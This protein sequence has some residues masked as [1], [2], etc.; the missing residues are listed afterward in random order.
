MAV[1]GGGASGVEICAE[2]KQLY[3]VSWHQLHELMKCTFVRVESTIYCLRRIKRLS[4]FTQPMSS[5]T[6]VHQQSFRNKWSL[7]WSSKGYNLFWVRNIFN[8]IFTSKV[9]L[10]PSSLKS[11]NRVSN[12]EEITSSH[13]EPCEVRTQ[14][15]QTYAVD[16]AINC[17]GTSK[18]NLEFAKNSLGIV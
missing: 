16:C 4:C 6:T 1:I 7:S 13:F 14:D 18:I 5:Y 8:D 2:I 17:T 11:G 10:Q 12:L 9:C 15:G 3:K